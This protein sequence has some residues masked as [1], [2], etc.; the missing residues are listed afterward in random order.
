MGV[1]RAP[2]RPLESEGRAEPRGQAQQRGQV[3]VGPL[4]PAAGPDQLEVLQQ[5]RAGERPAWPKGNGVCRRSMEGPL[6]GSGHA[7]R[8]RKSEITPSMSTIRSGALGWLAAG[9]RSRARGDCPLSLAIGCI[10]VDRR[11]SFSSHQTMPGYLC[12]GTGKSAQPPGLTGKARC[13]I[14]ADSCP[15]STAT[16]IHDP[17]TSAYSSRSPAL[18]WRTS[19]S[20]TSTGEPTRCRS[21]PAT[22]AAFGTG[23]STPR[24]GLRWDGDGLRSAGACTSPRWRWR[25]CPSSRSR[26]PAASS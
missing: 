16:S 2:G 13:A 7:A 8:S 17:R 26:S 1:L 24:S 20:S 4:L 25:R 5:G 12:P 14:T 21:Q 22:P 9:A 19:G 18:S 15:P 3:F 23:S 10:W 11:P 6:A